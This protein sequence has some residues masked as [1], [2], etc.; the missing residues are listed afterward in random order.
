MTVKTQELWLA[1]FPEL[2]PE[3]ARLF[4]P[5]W[6]SMFAAFANGL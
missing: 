4:K 3:Q 5:P 2:Y 6:T 1:N